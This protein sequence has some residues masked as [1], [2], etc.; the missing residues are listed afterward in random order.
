MKKTRSS[1][2]ERR[3]NQRTQK[4]RSSKKKIFDTLNIRTEATPREVKFFFLGETRQKKKK[5]RLYIALC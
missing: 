3:E 4:T 1:S 2:R 5:E